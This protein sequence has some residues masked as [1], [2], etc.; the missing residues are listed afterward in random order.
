MTTRAQRDDIHTPSREPGLVDVLRLVQRDTMLK[1]HVSAPGKIVTFDP[2]TQKASISTE[3]LAVFID[4]NGEDD[5]QQPFTIPNVPVFFMQ[6]GPSHDTMPMLPGT[7]GLLVVSDRSLGKWLS[8]GVPADPGLD[9]AHREEDA[10]FFPGFH[11]DNNPIA[12]FDM[13]AR[14]IEA[15]QI[16]I[17]KDAASKI[18]KAE[19]LLAAMDAAISAAILAAVGIVPPNGGDGGTAAFTAFQTAWNAQK[20]NIL[21][22]KGNVE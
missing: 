3:I 18:A 16:K 4:A 22:L 13:T 1:I 2:N 8:Q 14:V 12:N 6:S 21:A 19:E 9:H 15:L 7:T 20:A 10:V 5:L 11:P 17:G